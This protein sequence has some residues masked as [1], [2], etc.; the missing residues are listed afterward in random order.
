MAIGAF[1]EPYFGRLETGEKLS[2]D[3]NCVR[4]GKGPRISIRAMFLSG[5]IDNGFAV[6]DRRFVGHV[7][8][9]SGVE[10]RAHGSAQFIL[11]TLSA[12]ESAA[13]G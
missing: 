4:L 9:Y 6:F 12:K 3:L 7:I 8:A 13:E 2:A 11:P 5:G 1:K 10:N